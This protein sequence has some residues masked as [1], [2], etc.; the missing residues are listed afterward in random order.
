MLN[1]LTAKESEQVSIAVSTALDHKETTQ[2]TSDRAYYLL[3][4]ELLV[5]D[6]LLVHAGDVLFVPANTEY[7]FQ[8][9]FKAILMNSPPFRAE[10]EAH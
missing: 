3:E 7:T 4:G 5:N 8:G 1:L 10:N 9:T 2:T 6:E